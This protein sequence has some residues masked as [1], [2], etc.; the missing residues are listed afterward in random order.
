MTDMSMYDFNVALLKPITV[1]RYVIGNRDGDGVDSLVL[2]DVTIDKGT[3]ISGVVIAGSGDAIKK[4]LCVEIRYDDRKWTWFTTEEQFTQ[5]FGIKPQYP[6]DVFFYIEKKQERNI[7]SYV[8]AI[9]IC[10]AIIIGV[11]AT[12]TSG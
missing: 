1:T 9:M 6:D 12:F 4:N 5:T 8:P 7:V 2:T 10:V 3:T 11:I